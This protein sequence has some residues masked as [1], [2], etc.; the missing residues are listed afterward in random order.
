MRCITF[1]IGKIIYALNHDKMI[2][3]LDGCKII[4][5]QKCDKFIEG[6]IVYKDENIPIFNP[7]RKLH[8]ERR[9]KQ[10]TCH[11]I[12][13]SLHGQTIGLSRYIMII[14]RKNIR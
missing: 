7:R 11:I 1:K 6:Y 3:S 2:E 12:V 5:Q 10:R 4:E 9:K 13:I 14:K 8:I